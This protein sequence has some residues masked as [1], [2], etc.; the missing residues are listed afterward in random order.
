MNDDAAAAAL[1]LDVPVTLLR[2]EPLDRSLWHLHLV[3]LHVPSGSGCD[4]PLLRGPG[5]FRPPYL[6]GVAGSPT[7]NPEGNRDRNVV[8][9]SAERAFTEAATDDK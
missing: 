7:D 8:P 4:P 2:V 6:H 5:P 9:A 1:L 3:F